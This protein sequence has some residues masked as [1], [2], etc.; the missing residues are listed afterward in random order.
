MNSRR[1]TLDHVPDFHSRYPGEQV[2]LFTRV[3]AHRVLAGAT[4]RVYLPKALTLERYRMLSDVPDVTAYIEVDDQ[5]ND[6]VT[7]SFD[8]GL[9]AGACIECQVV[10]RVAPV[11]RDVDIESRAVLVDSDFEVLSEEA[12]V[13][14]VRAKGDYLRLLP[15]FYEEDEFMGR[16]L[17]LFESFWGPIERQVDT[18]HAYINPQMTPSQFL[19]W[20]ASWLNLTLDERLPEDRQRQLLR[21]AV[22]L[23][24]RRGTRQGLKDYL[25]IYTGGEAHII[26]HRAKDFRLGLAARLGPGIA[27][28]QTNVP[29]TFTVTLR[30]PPVEVGEEASEEEIAARTAERRRVIRS[31][32]D[33]E[34]PAH[35]GY[36]LVLE[37]ATQAIGE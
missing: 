16:F 25:E 17:M 14:T 4:L 2:V 15:E 18:T 36:N 24:R 10:T 1:A 30:L 34:K 21:A 7:W 8:S 22:P 27:L 35:T 32:I 20:L 28:G 19:P 11:P 33:T 29:H 31:I 26:E 23:Y 12:S 6:I 37:V 3:T 5:Q 13:V 9:P